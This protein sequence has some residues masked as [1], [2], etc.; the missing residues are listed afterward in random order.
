MAALPEWCLR[1][2]NLYESGAA[3]QF[4][5]TGNVPDAWPLPGETSRLG[6]LEELL[7]AQLLR[8]FQ[9]VFHYDLAGGLRLERGG[10]FFSKWP[11]N[12]SGK[13]LPRHPFEAI[14]L[15]DHYFRYLA[16][17]RALGTTTPS[18]GLVLR[19]AALVFPAQQS[20]PSHELGAAMLQVRAWSS[21]PP[22]VE[23]PLATFLL[24]ENLN[25]LHPLISRNPRAER[26]ELPMPDAPALEN[27]LQCRFQ[28]H[29]AL[30]PDG[31]SS[32]QLAPLLTGISFAGVESI[33][34]SARHAN[35][36][37][38]ITEI[39]RRKQQQ[40]ERES[41]GLIDFIRSEN[42][43][44][45]YLGHEPL[46]RRL[47][48]DITLWEQG[49]LAALPMGYLLCGPVG[50]GKTYLVNCLAGEARLPVVRIRNF[51][52]RWIGSTEGNL[53]KIFRMLHALGRAVVFID[54][55]DQALG[56]RE[57]SGGDSGVSSRVYAM[58]A[59][60]MSR[61]G[62]RGRLLWIL[63]TS[64][65][66]LVEV[67]LKRPGRVDVKIP[68]FPCATPEETW[69]L[70]V[71]MARTRGI[72]LAEEPPAD[73]PLPQNLT[74]GT[75]EALVVNLYR[76]SRAENIR[77]DEALRRSLADYRPAIPPETMEFQIRLAAGEASDL[78]L[79]PECFRR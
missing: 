29:P 79:I 45:D 39:T 73:L 68:I 37:L 17:V 62:N 44:A 14:R 26:I 33:L 63:A 32:S 21:H 66:D 11:S 59:E 50:T 72:D 3:S 43:L 24:A 47:R 46:K 2:A 15:L 9:V 61:S 49:D 35:T 48:Q 55:A 78:S 57:S 6:P 69:N 54:E 10:D 76:Q 77:P 4:L 20:A 67:D 41:Q 22:L 8:R 13:S 40:L 27:L 36:P 56:R 1:I 25:D 19:D 75:A 53:E 23:L 71:G 31:S 5:L 52:D 64:R 51:R 16:N 58:F 74:P 65:P 30:V 60:E 42:S 28:E 70:L 18:V 7:S 38:S 12:P 34:R